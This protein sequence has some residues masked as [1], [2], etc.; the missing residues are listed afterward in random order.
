MKKLIQQKCVPCEGGI[1]PLSR[2]KILPLLSEVKKW[3]VINGK[4]IERDFQFKNFKQALLFINKAGEVAEKEKHHPDIL[5]FD[6]NNVRII[7]WTHAIS[8][9]S[10]NDFIVAAKIDRIRV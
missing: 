4:K 8:G 1:P 5:L 2:E 3:K 7:L 10:K 9:L 6:F